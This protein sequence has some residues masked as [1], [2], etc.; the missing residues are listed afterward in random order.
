MPKEV[1]IIEKD[2]NNY[3]LANMVSFKSPYGILVFNSQLDLTDWNPAIE[4]LIG[5]SR[6]LCIGQ[7]LLAVFALHEEIIKRITIKSQTCGTLVIAEELSGLFGV[8][9]LNGIK[10]SMVVDKSGSISGGTLIITTQ[11][12]SLQI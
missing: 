8:G 2:I 4:R 12:S 10:I 3:Q 5:L 7:N 9:A 11:D 6:E 1:S